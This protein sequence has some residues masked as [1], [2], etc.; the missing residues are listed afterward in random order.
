MKS[1]EAGWRVKAKAA[2]LAGKKLKP[3]ADVD[4]GQLDLGVDILT[5]CPHGSTAKNLGML[6]TPQF[7]QRCLEA[8]RGEAL[9]IDQ[10]KDTAVEVIGTLFYL[11]LTAKTK[12]RN[13]IMKSRKKLVTADVYGGLLRHFFR[14]RMLIS[15]DF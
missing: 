5:I 1:R 14:R 13:A 7:V 10:L 9:T 8:R 6:Y 3:L 12:K 11:I 15:L 4:P 2:E